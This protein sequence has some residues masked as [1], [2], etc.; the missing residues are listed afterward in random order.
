[1]SNISLED[2]LLLAFNTPNFVI[3]EELA[4]QFNFRPDLVLRN[5]NTVRGFII[6]KSD[7]IPFEFIDRFSEHTTIEKCSIEKYIVFANKPDKETIAK[8]VVEKKIAVC[9]PYR[10]NIKT[11][12][13]QNELAEQIAVAV[14]PPYEMPHTVVFF[15]SVEELPERARGKRIIEMISIKYKKAIFANLVERDKMKKTM[16]ASELWKEIFASIDKDEYFLGILAEEFSSGVEGE[17]QRAM[18]IK[19]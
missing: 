15:S 3:A 1:M 16:S 2:K 7:A 9:Y 13:P 12:L 10:G 5:E 8:C 19:T 6:R 4:A 14:V 18:N 11:I 17:I